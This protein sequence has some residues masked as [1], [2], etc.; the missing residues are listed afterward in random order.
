MNEWG[1]ERGS[2][3]ASLRR[4]GKNKKKLCES[5]GQIRM[6]ES[7]AAANRMS[8]SLVAFS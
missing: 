7:V 3:K 2:D 4:A 8:G 6:E 1:P 5:D